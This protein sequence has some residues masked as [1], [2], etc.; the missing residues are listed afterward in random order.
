MYTSPQKSP[1]ILPPFFFFSKRHCGTR[2]IL[3]VDGAVGQKAVQPKK[4]AGEKFQVEK[5][6]RQSGGVTFFLFSCFLS[7]FFLK[8]F[9]QR[10]FWVIQ[11]KYFATFCF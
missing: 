6:H 4:K 1:A 2:S 9:L 3:Q 7:F 11:H 8:R 5:G 10:N